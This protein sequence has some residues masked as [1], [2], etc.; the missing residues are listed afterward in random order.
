[1]PSFLALISPCSISRT[2]L[3]LSVAPWKQDSPRKAGSLR[4]HGA[5]FPGVQLSRVCSRGALRGDRDLGRQRD[6][7]HAHKASFK[8]GQGRSGLGGRG[9]RTVACNCCVRRCGLRRWAVVCARV[10]ACRALRFDLIENGVTHYCVRKAKSSCARST[11]LRQ[12]QGICLLSSVALV[13]LHL[14]AFVC[15]P[16]CFNVRDRA[17][18]LPTEMY[19]PVSRLVVF[20]SFVRGWRE[21]RGFP[22]PL[23]SEPCDAASGCVQGEAVGGRGAGGHCARAERTLGRRPGYRGLARC[24]RERV[25]IPVPQVKG[26]SVTNEGCMC[27]NERGRQ[28]KNAKRR[29]RG[30]GT[31]QGWLKPVER[32]ID[33]V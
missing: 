19:F 7:S 5:D 30:S 14:R 22:S 23:L 2:S 17:N 12:G 26:V 25:C 20:Y 11:F 21:Q 15:M 29:S 27:V 4:Q 24:Y 6:E 3:R 1:M 18:C 28:R 13:F 33:D 9:S 8:G 31:N 16:F 32:D 10:C